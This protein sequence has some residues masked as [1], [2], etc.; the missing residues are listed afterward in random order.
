MLSVAK[1]RCLRDS[2]RDAGATGY[3]PCARLAFC[4]TLQ[5]ELSPNQAKVAANKIATPNRPGPTSLARY[6]AYS[7]TAPLAKVI[8]MTRKITPITSNHNWCKTFT[9]DRVVP[10]TAPHAAL[11]MRLRPACR[12]ATWATTPNF[13][14]VETFAT[15]S[16]LA[17]CG[18]TMSQRHGRELFCRGSHLI[19]CS[20]CSSRG[21]S[22]IHN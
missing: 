15:L 17:A 9:N 20:W 22:W 11:T 4:R 14:A 16:I 10:R 13:R 8:A 12:P 7:L 1:A 6:F 5:N 19:G 21:D 18:A 2:R 3:D